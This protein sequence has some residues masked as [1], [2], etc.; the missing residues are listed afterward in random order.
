[1]QPAI[2]AFKRDYSE[3]FEYKGVRLWE[4]EIAFGDQVGTRVDQVFRF[5]VLQPCSR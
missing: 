3:F 1:M 2:E 5:K 4:S